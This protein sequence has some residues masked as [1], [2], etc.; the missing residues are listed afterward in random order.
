MDLQEF[1]NFCADHF[2][3]LIVVDFHAR[4][5]GPCKAYGPTFDGLKKKYSKCEFLKI[6]IDEC[7]E[8]VDKFNIESVPTFVF[9]KG[10]RMIKKI[11]GVEH[12]QMIATIEQYM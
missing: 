3:Q 4:W 5:C 10:G 1:T 7:E 6:D 12:D 8:L 2:Q 11:V 9:M